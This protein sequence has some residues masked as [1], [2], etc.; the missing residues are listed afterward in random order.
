MTKWTGVIRIQLIS[1]ETVEAGG[2]QLSPCRESGRV[3][4]GRKAAERWTAEGAEERR[5]V[6]RDGEASVMAGRM[7]VLRREHGL[8][9]VKQGG[10]AKEV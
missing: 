7:M 6:F 4:S 9:A 1:D 10:T 3:R 5:R 2:R 8:S